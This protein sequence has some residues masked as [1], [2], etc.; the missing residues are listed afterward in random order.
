MN[1]YKEIKHL[2]R[3]REKHF[4]KKDGTM[5]AQMYSDD[6]H[7][8]KNGKYEEIDNTL[9]KHNHKFINKNNAFR[10]SFE[11]MS[12]GKFMSVESL[13]HTLSMDLKNKL[14][15]CSK[16]RGKEALY[17]DLLKGIDIKYTVL[18]TKIK[19]AIVLKDKVNI[20]KQLEFIIDTD[21]ELTIPNNG[22]IEAKEK[23]NTIFVIEA[24]YM[25]D[26]GGLENHDIYYELEKHNTHYDIL[27]KLDS[28]WLER[29][30]FPVTIDPTIT[31]SDQGKNVYDTYIYPGDTGVDRNSKDHLKMGVERVNN[32]DIINRALLKFELP[33][34]GTGSQV[35]D[36]EIDLIGYPD[37]KDHY[38]FYDKF[39]SVHRMTQDWNEA[40]A[41]WN[42][43]HDKYDS[44]IEDYTTIYLSRLIGNE[45]TKVQHNTFDITNLVKKWY[46]GL[47]NY[48][49]LLK[50][51]REVY[52]ED[53]LAKVFSKNNSVVG[54]NPKPVLIVHYRNQNGLES[55]MDYQTENFTDGSSLSNL[56]NGNLVT[57][58]N[59]GKTISGKFPVSLNL[60]YNTNDV[61][62]NNNYGYGLGYQVNFHQL[63]KE[64]TIG[65]YQTLEFKDEDGTLHYFYKG[66]DLA[67]DTQDYP[68]NPKV[69]RDKDTYY[70]EDGLSLTITKDTDTYI[71]KDNDGNTSLFIHRGSAWYLSKITD[72]NSNSVDILYDDNNKITKVIDGNDQEITFTYEPNKIIVTSSNET[73][74]LQY[75]NN[76]LVKLITKNGS[77]NIT[78]NN[79]KII[80]KITDVTGKSIG[81][82]YYNMIPYRI[83]KMTEYGIENGTGQHMEFVYGFNSTTVTDS[84]SGYYTYTFNNQ[85]NT[86]G[87]SSLNQNEAIKDAYGKLFE[88]GSKDRYTTSLGRMN[89]LI[90]ENGS[91]K[92]ANNYI[93]NSSF[94]KETLL[95]TG[96]ND[97]ITSIV[98]NHALTG[99]RC[100]RISSKPDFLNYD[101]S[102]S[103]SI[104]VPKGETYTFS[105]YINSSK[106]AY[107]KVSYI[108]SDNQVISKMDS[109]VNNQDYTRYSTT[110]F[111]PENA[112]SDL[113]LTLGIDPNS[114]GYFD[115]IQLEKGEVANLYNLVDNSDFSKGLGDWSA[116]VYSSY[117]GDPENINPL[118]VVT[119]E[120]GHHALK[121]HT[122]P[123]WNNVL[124]V[125]LPMSGKA[126]D[127]YYIYF[128]YKNTG[129][130]KVV[131]SLSQGKVMIDFD[132]DE[133]VGG[134]CRYPRGD[135]SGNNTEW[136]FFETFYTAE[137][138]Y[139]EATLTLFDSHANDLY[140][141][142]VAVYKPI[143]NQTSYFYDDNGNMT[144]MYDPTSGPKELSYD[145]N[146]QL[147]SMMDVKGS[148]FV[149]EY[150]N[151]IPDRILKGIS[152]TGI[153]NEIEYDEVGNPIVTRIKNIGELKESSYF[154]RKKGTKE[155]LTCN[156]KTNSLTLKQDT[157]SHDGFKLIKEDNYYKIIP[158]Y[159]QNYSIYQVDNIVILRKDKY[160]LFEFIK[161]Q[162][163]SYKIKLKDEELYLTYEENCLILKETGEE[164]YLEERNKQLFVENTATYTEDGKFVKE[165]KDTLGRIT[166]YDIDTST[167][168]TNSI[169]DPKN[170]TTYYTYN[171]KEQMAKVEKDFKKV[172]YEYNNQNLLSKIK[173]GTKEYNFTYDEFLNTKD[174]KIGNQ[175]LI[176]NNYESN[177]GNLKSSIYGN[178]DMVI[179]SYDE[180]DRIKQVD[181]ETG[182]YTYHYD[183]LGNIAKV[184]SEANTYQYYY[185]VRNR[186]IDYYNNTFHIRYDYDE[187][188]NVKD[189]YLNDSY[190]VNYEYNKDN[191]VAKVNMSNDV[192][193][194][195]KK[196]GPAGTG[197]W[198]EP[199]SDTLSYTYDEL[200]RMSE[201]NLN[202]KLK[203]QYHYITKGNR[204]SFVLDEFTS[205]DDKYSYK[206]DELDNITDISYNNVL[207]N[208]YEYDNSNELVKDDDYRRNVT[209]IYTYDNV[210]NLLSKKEYELH[211]ENLLKEDS[212]EYNNSN[213]EDQLTKFNEEEFTY[214][215]IGNP[216]MIGS[217][218]L[219]WTNGRQLEKIVD[220]E[221]E[222]K[223]KYNKDSI[224]TEKIVNGLSRKYYLENNQILFE[225]F[226]KN[227]IYY[228]RDDNNHLI[229]FRLSEETYYYVKNAQ[230]D[231]I[232]ILDNNYNKI[233]T[234]EYDA[235]GKILS[236][237]DCDNHEIIDTNH[238]AHINPFRYRSYYYDEE[239]GL[240]YLNSRYYNPSFGRFI[241]ADGTIGANEDV[242]S[243]NLFAYCSNNPI[244]STDLEGDFAFAIP[245][246]IAFVKGTA[247]A[248]GCLGIG[249]IGVAGL[250]YI[251]TKEIEKS[252][253]KAKTQTKVNVKTSVSTSSKAKIQYP[254]LPN[255]TVIYRYGDKNPSN[256]APKVKDL[257]VPPGVT[258]SLSF[259]LIPPTNGGKA[260]YTTIGA[261]KGTGI[262]NVAQDN[263]YHIAV[264]PRFDTIE[265]WVKLGSLHPCTAAVQS[266]VM[267]WGD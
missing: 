30:S 39:V 37:Y 73:V 164:F 197:G 93:D 88:Y 224:R 225:E 138:D 87:V 56:Y 226:G 178:G 6:I 62:L 119:L 172:E 136:Q 232:G 14:E 157:C 77:T 44:R 205:N 25:I 60:I 23:D 167:G 85:G 150:D 252:K 105:A 16:I 8:L 31:N 222:T 102:A 118:E 22:M 121:W 141:T 171:N 4:L 256:L 40:T 42:T 67:G 19:E 38:A 188:G 168:L 210:G 147:I 183:N 160:S 126:G 48:G 239:T 184:T 245:L 155:Y 217:K 250:G 144:H 108:D 76:Q 156:F 262:L 180:F 169:T 7:Y 71:M 100:F 3:P 101:H 127:T 111:Y 233:A 206:Y 2:R 89:K 186:L 242:I 181:K 66:N 257:N 148:N 69:V 104:K 198:K 20:P 17:Q 94:E 176:T 159:N 182:A 151:E 98:N 52:Y 201:K 267:K 211:T 230:E 116:R 21:L 264:T 61:I 120:N 179:Y 79:K 125:K 32:Q 55:Y 153:S 238:I 109:R 215:E 134:M 223:F 140:I 28:D 266:V 81:Y 142:N 190:H 123:D 33:T 249:A 128:W 41:N 259:S 90:S 103:Y 96:T 216:L 214:D 74:T 187:V 209:T 53:Y 64:V 192:D 129:I 219:S 227:M 99:N 91:I 207:I 24:P 135:Y 106:S 137:Y 11:E 194:D 72:T 229:G 122:E 34:I 191:A 49:V 36:A 234:Y 133:S 78:Y 50:S 235:W 97:V 29:A 263:I 45:I 65:K 130:E 114:Y 132:Y 107:I 15:V 35:I 260:V 218:I 254:E 80:S 196:D 193:S 27:L 82:E 117:K 200:G 166:T 246:G 236:I 237:K 203:N 75:Q 139:T 243:H 185:D 265:N 115:D 208:H 189:K 258:K 68:D 221:N 112:K 174:I 195:V 13:G 162:N 161:N 199:Y 240:Y 9:E 12:S 241:N 261:L 46:S 152:V 154:I 18:P 244:N 86:I 170:I 149:Y 228:I 251:G 95:F 173:H 145:K 248:I 51:H 58:W 110:I 177:N 83:K 26:S 175:A 163:G 131:P 146:N 255:D 57:T 204:T 202:D 220:G 143:S 124:S 43:M 165:T 213:W 253:T 212:Y 113:T 70:D 84:K 47:P 231:I 54:D 59:I 10:A 92:I 247:A 158:V 63:L 5:I 1:D